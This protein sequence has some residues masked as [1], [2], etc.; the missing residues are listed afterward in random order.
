M[1]FGPKVVVALFFLAAASS[2]HA[3][4]T[5]IR[6]GVDGS[7]PPFN[8]VRSDGELFGYDIDL[9]KALCA[10]MQVECSFAKVDWN[11]I[12]SDLESGE[13]D[14]VTSVSIT[15]ERRKQADFTAPYYSNKLQF[16]AAKSAQFDPAHLSGKV[17]GVQRGTISADWLEKNVKDARL[18]FYGKQKE[19]W[20]D[21]VAG[22]TSG[23]LADSFVSWKWLTTP[24]G[25]NFEF[26]GKP[27]LTNDSIGIAVAKGRNDLVNRL[28]RALKEIR[29]NGL[30]NLL[31]DKYF[32]FVND[33]ARK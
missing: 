6:F 9:A 14:A 18:V 31:N 5:V 26:K 7:F 11:R 1:F 22:K 8:D 24:A 29:D 23:V 20:D 25:Q 12:F 17:L 15:E 2:A 21:L 3:D 27:V 32:S 13:I 10:Q 16:V 33:G 28:N 30:Y 4:D 19:S